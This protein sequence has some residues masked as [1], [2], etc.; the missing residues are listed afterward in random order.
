MK[1]IA[2]LG[3]TGSIGTQ[4][5]DII[6]AFP[7]S[8]KVVGLAARQSINLLESQ[9]KE[10][11]PKLFSLESTPEN[12]RR[13]ESYGSSKKDMT[14]MV[15]DPDVDIVV[16]STAGDVALVPTIEAIK[17][18][19]TI[20][21]ANKESIIIAGP[22]IMGLANH[23]GAQILPVD[24]EPSAIWQCLKGERIE[25]TYSPTQVSKLIITASG[26]AFRN[27]DPSKLDSV[28]PGQA[29]K[30]PT[31]QM[32]AKI[33]VDS[34][35]LMN[36]A[37]EVIEAHYL[38]GIPWD[39]IDVVIHPQSIIHSMVEFDDGSMKAHLGMPNMKIPIQYALFYPDRIR[40][41]SIARFDPVSHG[42]LTFEAMDSKRYPCFEMALEFAKRGGTWPA[43]LCGADESAVELFISGKIKFTD[44]PILIDAA[45]KTYNSDDNP[46]LNQCLSATDWG[47]RRVK[48]LVNK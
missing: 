1:G 26:G 10:F 33:T 2:I 25:N 22:L 46:N 39:D 24:S 45:L 9:V 13:L 6:R 30:H 27:W 15:L 19:K 43:A 23:S 3:S 8:L 42:E 17:A 34:A 21:L 32:G 31:W 40:N 12:I 4:T 29:L 35:T 37:F 20:A 44:I 5:L 41:H 28:T 38:F 16:T 18:G 7:D 36:K 11:H 47:K 14:T 48:E